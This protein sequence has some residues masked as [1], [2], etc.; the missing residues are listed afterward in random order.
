MSR[1]DAVRGHISLSSAFTRQLKRD[2]SER[3]VY[4]GISR[5]WLKH[6]AHCRVN[7]EL[8][9]SSADF[10]GGDV[11]F[12]PKSAALQECQPMPK[13][14]P[15]RDA[16]RQRSR[17]SVAAVGLLIAICMVVCAPPLVGAP[18]AAESEVGHWMLTTGRGDTVPDSS[19]QGNDARINGP[20]WAR[21]GDR[22][23]LDFDGKSGVV[24]C[25][26]S[27]ALNPTEAIT[28]E[29]WVFPRGTGQGDYGRIVERGVYGLMMHPGY[30]WGLAFS[31]QDE[32]GETHS[33][34]LGT[35]LPFRHWYHVVGT[36]DGNIQK[37]FVNG[38]KGDVTATWSGKLR[39]SGNHLLIGNIGRGSAFAGA[40]GRT[41]DGFIDEV[42]VFSRTLMEDE[43]MTRYQEGEQIRAH[44][45]EP[46]AV[47]A[48]TVFVETFADP[49][50]ALKRWEF[51]EE[52]GTCRLSLVKPCKVVDSYAAYIDFRE[53]GSWRF[54]ARDAVMLE[55]G[56]QYTLSARVR[57]RLGYTTTQLLVRAS[58]TAE[59]GSIAEVPVTKRLNELH[60]VSVVFVA[61]A[62]GAAR[63]G[64]EG[65]GYSEVW[66]DEVKLRRNVPPLS[67]YRTGLLL[68]PSSPMAQARFRTG[69]FFEAEDA[70]GSRD[71]VTIEDKDGDG[72]WAVCRVDP[73]HNPWLFSD[74]TV[75]KSDS[76]AVK[77]GRQSPPLKLT[78]TDL[79]PGLY[80]VYLS[81]TQR[82]AA[83]SLDGV[84]WRR[85]KG[86]TGENELGL[87]RIDR[88]FSVWIRHQ[89]QTPDN[90][91]PIYVD[92][93][94]FM[95]VY[96]GD[97]APEEPAEFAQIEQSALVSTTTMRLWNAGGLTRHREWVTAGM[98][99]AM[100]A[101]R[102]SD[103]IR[104]QG[105]T[106]LTLA[107]NLNARGRGT[108]APPTFG[109]PASKWEA[110]LAEPER[111][112]RPPG[113]RVTDLAAW[114]LVLWPDGSVKWLR[115]TFR[116][117]VAAGAGPEFALEYGRDIEP[118]AALPTPLRKTADG[119]ELT[120]GTCEV[121]VAN[122][123]WDGIRFRDKDV[124]TAPPSVRLRTASGMFLDQLL[125]ESVTVE[126]EGPRP[127]IL[128][129]GHLGHGGTPGPAA[130]TAR[131][132]E[133]ATNTLALDFS[134]VNESKEKYQRERGCSPAV[135]LEELTLVLNG[136]GIVPETLS[137]PAGRFAFGPEPQTLVQ[138]GSGPCAAE[139]AGTWSL[140]AGGRELAVGERSE[141]WVDLCQGDIGLTVGVRGFFEKCPTSIA[142]R[143]SGQGCAVEVG[144][145]PEATGQ[146]LRYA[147]GTQLTAQVALA[148]HDGTRKADVSR[149][150]LASVL[151]PLRAVLPVEH[152]A[153]TGIFGPVSPERGPWFPGFH[154]SADKA[155]RDLVS[156]HRNYGVEDWGD[157]F[158]DCGYVRGTNKLWTNMEWDFIA[159][160]IL[161]FIRTGDE[162]RLQCADEA[163]QHFADID[164]IHYSSKPGWRGA[165][166]V[167]T[168]DTREGHQVDTPNFAHAGWAQGLLW[169]YYLCGD[170]RLAE[171][172]TGLADYV[173][174]N[175]PPPGPYRRPP[176]FSMW[177]NARASGNPIL[178]L[179]SAYE[180]KRAPRY[181]QALDRIVDYALRVQDPKLGCWATPRYESPAYHRVSASSGGLFFRG[182]H[183]Y[184]QQTGDRRIVR[185]FERF[186][187]FL[188]DTHPNE[189]RRDLRTGSYCRTSFSYT[190]EALALALLFSSNPGALRELAETRMLSVFPGETPTAIGVRGIPGKISNGIHVAGAVS[191][192]GIA[193]QAEKEERMRD[194]AI[195]EV[196]TGP[197]VNAAHW[198]AKNGTVHKERDRLELRPTGAKASFR[199]AFYASG[200]G[201]V[202]RRAVLVFPEGVTDTVSVHMVSP[203]IQWQGKAPRGYE[204]RFSGDGWILLRG[205]T[206]LARG[207]ALAPGWRGIQ[208]ALETITLDRQSRCR[209]NAVTVYEG[210]DDGEQVSNEGTVL[211]RTAADAVDL[212]ALEEDFIEPSVCPSAWERGNVLLENALGSGTAG[213]WVV[214]GREPTWG[215]NEI[216]LHHTSVVWYKHPFESPFVMEFE[217]T[218]LQAP[219]KFTAGVS[220]SIWFWL[221][222]DP[223][224]PDDFFA[225]TAARNANPSLRSYLPLRFYWIDFGGNNNTTTRFRYNPLRQLIRQFSDAPRLLEKGR[226]YKIMIV[227][228]GPHQ[229]YWCDG[230]RWAYFYDD[231]PPRSGHIGFRAFVADHRISNLRIHRLE[232]K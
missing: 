182:L 72:K 133:A 15:N 225:E 176:P 105:V 194:Y 54:L 188:L 118:A 59:T 107:R 52:S 17:P 145:W 164:I 187:A 13:R 37:L 20:R 7:A 85:V 178:T 181:K 112:R 122:D 211:V 148:F 140:T 102:P 71:A 40:G 87:L 69:A 192:A 56:A 195:V 45:A 23:V 137:W 142:V 131:I 67:P 205:Q 98:P 177:N 46:A 74:N 228:N 88:E 48:H 189:T 86:G 73:E 94:R 108:E 24:D 212:L 90:P 93:L 116:A 19:S 32:A 227:A 5:G 132:R 196:N 21:S 180:L 83:I 12:R 147:Q 121:R 84:K 36:F 199:W 82:D 216:V 79:L 230:K 14:L 204:Y 186:G 95:P 76:A 197:A 75:I 4:G 39:T 33:S 18:G 41:F 217:T 77:E 126:H 161:D 31:V 185:A 160:L 111:S 155:Y 117:D 63:V 113:D 163:A 109:Q 206:E 138:T 224:H 128:V 223:R 171:A 232:L 2:F 209:L 157:F 42:A 49:D 61:K 136:V 231:D 81:D 183:V 43:M 202:K 101:F 156:R 150:H 103:G 26:G 29:A 53:K 6:A 89:F 78:A 44:E 57:R 22:N 198:V 165:S 51:T 151:Q 167:H 129:C 35:V 168:G 16:A 3:I 119:Y 99:F 154:A 110:V 193:T 144:I 66:I 201:D 203:T 166:Y 143:R 153:R 215:T 124:V 58:D 218:P 172:A 127:T 55:A 27:E 64:F 38:V 220:D 9:Q 10:S 226:T 120:A 219:P 47:D 158:S 104:I 174:N 169:C 214:E 8:R 152:Y 30:S 213:D 25:G 115:L 139:F 146:T 123:V 207:P 221:A 50:T 222:S 191:L 62:N 135:A 114:P 60:E 11:W 130:F 97:S 100:G 200:G 28:V 68:T 210:T 173:V 159:Y 184:W 91:G 96:E 170:E 65:S 141:G 125:V 70:V 179:C 80:Q 162:G 92:Y 149:E 190:G 134:V 106:D 208:I 175:M 229:E 1:P 34:A